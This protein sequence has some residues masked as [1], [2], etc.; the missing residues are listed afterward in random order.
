[1]IFNQKEIK[2]K[3][4][5]HRYLNRTSEQKE[6][7]KERKRLHAQKHKEQTKQYR[8]KNKEKL[9]TNH[10]Q[11]YL[12]NRTHFLEKFKKY[13]EEFL[14]GNKKPTVHIL[15]IRAKGRA[16]KHKLPFNLIEENIIIPE[17][18]PIFKTIKLIPGSGQGPNYNA[19]SLDRIDPTLGY[20]EG[21][22]WIISILANT[23][24]NNATLEQLHEFSDSIKTL[25]QFNP[26]K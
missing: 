4:D 6:K 13:K 17:F 12:N 24:K 15:W 20:V 21:N 16:K 14:Q 19:P 9:A 25:P 22:C 1:M 7:D 5:K 18:C 2:S 3:Y 10:H 26:I 8:V 23:M 11:Y